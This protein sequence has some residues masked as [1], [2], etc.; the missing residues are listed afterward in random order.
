MPPE[1]PN[2]GQYMMAA[3]I[4]TAAIYLLYSVSLWL[5]VRRTSKY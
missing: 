2:N 5:R 4:I 3:Y 1:T